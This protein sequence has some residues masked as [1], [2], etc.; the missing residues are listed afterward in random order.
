M[1]NVHALACIGLG[2]VFASTASAGVVVTQQAAA[3]PTYGNV[4]DFDL[5]TAPAEAAPNTWAA[6]GL[7]SFTDGGNPFVPIVNVNGVYPWVPNSNV[8]SGFSFGLFMTFDPGV[9][10]EASFQIWSSAGAPGPF[11]GLYIYVNDQ[12]AAS[13]NP[14]WGGVGDTWYDV[15]TNGGSTINSVAIIAGGFGFP[16]LFLDNLSWN[17]PT[18]GAIALLMLGG[19]T[20]RRRR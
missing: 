3:A 14:S 4:A 17:V 2:A 10:T 13:V 16:E 19:L 1:R 5:F 11:S 7:A 6:S 12:L 20:G 18:P 15:T 8:V 9:V